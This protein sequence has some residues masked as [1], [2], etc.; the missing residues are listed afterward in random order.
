[1][2]GLFTARLQGP[3]L[4]AL[5]DDLTALFDGS[6]AGAA[7]PDGGV[8]NQQPTHRLLSWEVVYS[9]EQMDHFCVTLANPDLILLDHPALQPNARW[10]VR[11]GVEGQLCQPIDCVVTHRQ[12][13]F[14]LTIGGEM[15]AERKLT[16][17]QQQQKWTHK[18]LSDVARELFTQ[19]GL[20]AVVDDTKQLLP[21]IV[22]G[23]ETPWQFLQRKAK[24]TGLAYTFPEP[25]RTTYPLA[26]AG[27][28][29]AQRGTH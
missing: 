20:I 29:P 2:S 26:T 23:H 15:Q 12:G 22:R 1:M 17:T 8:L 11:F 18:R 24:E 4:S 19:A 6:N 21:V 13:W 16:Q 9:T 25:C 5:G 10:K 28:T 27:R 7:V 3:G 14:Q